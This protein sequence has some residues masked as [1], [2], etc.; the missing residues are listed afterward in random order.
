MGKGLATITRTELQAY[1]AKKYNLPGAEAIHVYYD[2]ATDTVKVAVKHESIL[3]I[4]FEGAQLPWLEVP[5]REQEPETSHRIPLMR[6]C[7]EKLEHTGQK[8]KDRLTNTEFY[9]LVR[10]M[11]LYLIEQAEQDEENETEVWRFRTNS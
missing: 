5:E 1:I 4:D 9:F 11:A 10:N 6:E 8:H 2:P 7:L 3:S